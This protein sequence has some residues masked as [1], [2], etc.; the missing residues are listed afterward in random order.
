M[1]NVRL[2]MTLMV[3]GVGLGWTLI[4]PPAASAQCTFD[5]GPV[6]VDDVPAA[7]A[8][9]S[10]TVGWTHPPLPFGLDPQCGLE[11]FAVS[12]V[13]WISASRDLPLLAYPSTLNYT[14]AANPTTDE[15][16]G[17][18]TVAGQ[19]VTITQLADCPSRPRVS[20]TSLEF[21]SAGGWKDVTV[22]EAAHCRYAVNGIQTWVG[23][24]PTTVAGNGTVRVTVQAH[25][26]IRS[27]VGAVMIGSRG[28]AV[29]QDPPDNRPPVANAGADQ[30]VDEGATV[31]LNGT[32]SSDPDD[33]TLSYAWTQTSGTSVTLTNAATA[34]PTFTAPEV[35]ADTALVFTLT[36][37]DGNTSDTDTVTVTVEDT[38]LPNRPPVANASADQ[39]VDEGDPVTLDG[40]GSSDP[41]GHTLTYAWTQTSG[42]S[43]TLTN[44]ATAQPTFTA[45]EVTAD[46][47]LVFTLTVSDG[48]TSDTDT[49]TVTV[50]DTTLPNLPPV[51]N[52]GPDQMVDEGD[53]VTLDG[54]GSSDP[55]GHTLTYAWTQDSETSV[56]LTNAATAQPTFTAPEVTADTP[57]EFTLTVSD[58]NTSDRDTVTVTVSAPNRPPTANA[59][60]DRTAAVGTT[61][62]LN[63]NLSRDPDGD[64]LQYQWTQ[65]S[66]PEVVLLDSTEFY[67]TTT[68]FEVIFEAP[69][70][71]GD[72]DL[73]FSLVVT[74]ARGSASEPATVTVTVLGAV[75]TQHR[76][77]LLAD[78]ASRGGRTGGVCALWN[79][80]NQTKKD[81][82]LWNTHRLQITG[83]LSD[84]TKL[85]AVYGRGGCGGI[86]H[87][88]TFMAM[89]PALRDKL[90]LIARDQNRTVLPKWRETRDL[91]CT[92]AQ[93]VAAFT[94][95]ILRWECPHQPFTA[96]IETFK[97]KPRGQI[98]F[99][100]PNYVVV[101][102]EYGP[103]GG[104][105]SCGVDRIGVPRS[106]VCPAGT[107]CSGGGPYT[108]C[109]SEHSDTIVYDSTGPY[110]RGPAGDTVTIT[111]ALSFE[112]DQDYSFPHKSAPSCNNMRMTY[113]EEYGDPNWQWRPTGCSPPM[114]V[115]EPEPDPFGGRSIRAVHMTELRQRVNALR[116]RFSLA[117]YN[118]TDATI[119]PEVTPAKAVHVTE[120]RTA[121]NEAYRAA[122][123]DAPDFTDAVITPRVTPIRQVHLNELRK[124]VVAL[125]P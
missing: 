83:M 109:T 93:I 28:V 62:R 2:R 57:L 21:S 58:G 112:M 66:G 44:A 17:T 110:T 41:E 74:D 52:A 87:N 46:T 13:N 78:L 125:E 99:F 24:S 104:F 101:S 105:D 56:T 123:R 10:V 71:P 6:T 29:F 37:S 45:P 73:E 90:V 106:D 36:V 11:W 48:N 79:S 108:G 121:L 124:A 5:V 18:L 115:T 81:V 76:E 26:G 12:N 47:A 31:T 49:V 67:S 55:E 114:G 94:V 89:T 30:T 103:G 82:F 91:A 88:R 25:S 1:L 77:R 60:S 3:A 20:R 100:G 120:L 32:G 27:R 111:D 43:V 84:V 7:G 40:T 53:P 72:D 122:N 86:E 59:G 16:T 15:R 68:E 97:D 34:Q 35:T 51:A 33:D 102:R 9:G 50:E 70:T 69:A 92:W 98:Q 107:T 80:L 4:A 19:T 95:T 61:V 65:T 85:Y 96:Q 54:T 38:T 8:S 14:V 119:T 64:S 63:G 116:Q 118:W 42:T 23:A 75:L 113:S 39:M 22:Q 117:A